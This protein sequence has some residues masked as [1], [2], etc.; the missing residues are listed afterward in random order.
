MFP[1]HSDSAPTPTRPAPTWP[2]PIRPA[3]RTARR[4]A[5]AA[6]VGLAMAGTACVD[7]QNPG[8][9]TESAQADI[10]FGVEA[11]EEAELAEL[12]PPPPAAPAPEAA[13]TN[14]PVSVS[15]NLNVP[16]SDRF[17]DRFGSTGGTIAPATSTCPSAPLGAA[18][19]SV[20]ER[21]TV[22]PP[23]EG[24]YR[25]KISGTRT[26]TVNGVEIPTE[27]SGF[28]PRLVQNVETITDTS[29]RFEV[30]QPLG[31]GTRVTTWLVNTDPAELRDP[32]STDTD[33]DG[34]GDGRGFKPPYVGENP[35][36]A[37]E[38]ARGIAIEA[39]E[40]FD[41]DGNPAGSFDAV[42]P[43]LNMP[44]PV[45]PG[46]GFQSA[47][48]DRQGQSIQIEGEVLDRQTVDACGELVDGWMVTQNIT[49]A[50]SVDSAVRS[51]EYIFSTPMG[52]LPISH[53][54]QGQIVDAATGVA[55]TFDLTYSIGQLVPAELTNAD[56]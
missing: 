30:V 25:F 56:A 21:N 3:Q 52:G 47:S 41:V 8:V 39:I 2:A 26:L 48:I 54:V 23:A 40:D 51:E 33:G 18:P 14:A 44:L 27:V 29:W 35:I 10:V 43:L 36:R 22:S 1:S 31:E 37:G 55:Q 19:S 49:A 53:R 32:L 11:A 15:R 20:A 6:L 4:R 17:S 9:R 38:P 24:L 7:A 46:E 42:P 5:T 16:T 34:L 50:Q 12:T 45:L 28:E 13:P